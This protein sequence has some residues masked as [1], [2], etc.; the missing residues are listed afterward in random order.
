MSKNQNN[1]LLNEELVDEF[2]DEDDLSVEAF[3]Q[4]L[5]NED[6]GFIIDARGELKSIY[7]PD[8]CETLP[9]HIIAILEACGIENAEE[10]YCNTPKVTLH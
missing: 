10:I 2:E 3:G 9:K 8:N 5:T 1:L 7:L 4:E 6:Y